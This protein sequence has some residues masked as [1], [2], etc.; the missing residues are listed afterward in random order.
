[1][2]SAIAKLVSMA[3][4]IVALTVGGSD[5]ALAAPTVNP[6]PSGAS[7]AGPPSGHSGN[8][9]S[10]TSSMTVPLP[11]AGRSGIT[12]DVSTFPCTIFNNDSWTSYGSGYVDSVYSASVTCNPVVPTSLETWS[13]LSW[14]G[15]TLSTAS[16]EA[17]TGCASLLS[18]STATWFPGEYQETSFTY[19]T[20][21]L[22][23]T[24]WSEGAY[25]PPVSNGTATISE[26][27]A[28]EIEVELT[29]NPVYIV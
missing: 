17:C 16:T 25:N 13:Q 22:I 5:A 27:N 29:T 7:M 23:G 18:G 26:V 4:A 20:M 3:A 9:G 1:M 24:A 12:P 8:S 6:L 14:N 11:S 2:S 21:P 10:T 15:G 19:I 28:N